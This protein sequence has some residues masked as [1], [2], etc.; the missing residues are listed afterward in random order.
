MTTLSKKVVV[1]HSGGMDSSLCLALAI[2]EFGCDQV[3]SLS[4]YYDHRHQC[5]LTQ[6]RK[7]CVDWQVDHVELSITCL[8]QITDNAL[9]R[10]DQSI[11]HVPGQAPNTLVVGR[12]GLMARIAA[13]HAHSLG[14]DYVDMG[15]M[16]LESANSGYRDCSRKYMDLMQAILSI[17]LD[18]PY[19]K[20]RT[21]LVFMTKKQTMECAHEIG[22]L[23]YLLMNT[24]TCYEGVPQ[25][26]CQICPACQL[27]NAG[28]RE[29]LQEH[30][31]FKMP[32]AF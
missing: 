7:I 21:P 2:Q 15:V 30:A 8:G 32:Y 26:G 22:L 23:D 25:Q 14:A 11:V 19:F 9:T 28:L 10:K 24:I 16:E 13:I 1:V 20:I 18:N 29:F 3:L 5:E 6:A 4:F 27:R 12:N 17:D 31:N